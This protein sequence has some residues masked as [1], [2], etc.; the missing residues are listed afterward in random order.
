MVSLALNS[1]GYSKI[2][3]WYIHNIPNL[4]VRIFSIFVFHILLYRRKEEKEE[5]TA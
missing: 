4:E 1:V 2:E 5:E 3:N